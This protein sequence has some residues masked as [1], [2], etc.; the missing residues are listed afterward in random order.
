MPEAH[1]AMDYVRKIDP[2]LTVKRLEDWIFVQPDDFALIREGIRSA[3][4]P[5]G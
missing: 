4:L 2:T 3:G 5:E 1:N